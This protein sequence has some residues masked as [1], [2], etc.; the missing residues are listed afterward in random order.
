MEE[1]FWKAFR[2]ALWC[3]TETLSSVSFRKG[4]KIHKTSL[5]IYDLT[6]PFIFG[7]LIALL[8]WAITGVKAKREPKR[9]RNSVESLTIWGG[10]IIIN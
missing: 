10:R 8:A 9:R 2:N 6:N 1:F 7:R 4:R 5:K 3:M